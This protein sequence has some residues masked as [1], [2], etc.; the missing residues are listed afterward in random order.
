MSDHNIIMNITV[1]I[2]Y[3]QYQ[4]ADD[5]IGAQST[6]FFVLFPFHFIR[7]CTLHRDIYVCV[8]AYV[9]VHIGVLSD[10]ICMYVCTCM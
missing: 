8:Y 2:N 3:I 5:I 1:N 7:Y 10:H 9:R 4:Y 6:S